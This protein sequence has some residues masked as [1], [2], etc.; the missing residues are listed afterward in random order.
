M[1]KAYKSAPIAYTL[2][3][4]ITDYDTIVIECHD[5]FSCGLYGFAN[6]AIYPNMLYKWFWQY[7]QRE[8][9]EQKRE[10]L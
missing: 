10:K 9:V 7:I 6:H 5:F 2:D 3:I 8:M 4:G 1:I